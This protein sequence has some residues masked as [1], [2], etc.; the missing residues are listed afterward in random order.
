M[1]T[2]D[3]LD[4]Q[5]D[6]FEDETGGEPRGTGAALPIACL[7]LCVVGALIGYYLLWIAGAIMLFASIV[8]GVLALR[9]HAPYRWMAI[10]GIVLSVIALIFAAAVISVIFFQAQ[11]MNELLAAA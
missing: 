7:V 11:Q 4:T 6:D 5:R 3:E 9:R 10:A 8:Y 1:S 2:H